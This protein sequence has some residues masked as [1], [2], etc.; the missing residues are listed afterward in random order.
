MQIQNIKIFDSKPGATGTWVNISNLVAFSVQVTGLDGNVWLETS[1]DP[2]VQIDGPGIGAPNAPSLT[3]FTPNYSAGHG[4]TYS[5]QTA[6]YYVKVTAITPW[7][8]TS[9]SAES[10]LTVNPPYQLVV[11]SPTGPTG[12]TAYNV[13]VGTTSAGEV[14]Q[15]TPAYAPQRNTDTGGYSYAQSGAVPLGQPWFMY[16]FKRSGATAPAV[17]NS[18][19]AA[20]GVNITGNLTAGGSTAGGEIGIFTGASAAMVNPSCLVWKWLRVMKTGGGAFETIA[21]LMG[22]NG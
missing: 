18:G 15:T 19:S 22:Q 8:E 11:N 14:L 16:A 20:S 12:A 9:A 17:D 7:G 4:T 13:Y 3:Q 21:Y 6:T 10:S 1:N 2:N 5:G